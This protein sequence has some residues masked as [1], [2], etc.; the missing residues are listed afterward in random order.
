MVQKQSGWN[1]KVVYFNTTK[2]WNRQWVRDKIDAKSCR[3]LH[4]SKPWPSIKCR[5]ADNNNFGN[6]LC[7]MGQ[8]LN[9]VENLKFRFLQTYNT[10]D[11]KSTWCYCVWVLRFQEIL[12]GLWD[13]AF[14]WKFWYSNSWVFSEEFCLKFGK[15]WNRIISQNTVTAPKLFTKIDSDR[16]KNGSF[17]VII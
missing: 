1:S 3:A 5:I 17:R 10:V 12:K 8:N 4:Q 2:I 11:S 14:S 6:F 13:L 9:F 15:E 7:T 16:L